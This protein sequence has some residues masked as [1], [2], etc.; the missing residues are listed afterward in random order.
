[1][2]AYDSWR[3]EVSS[4]DPDATDVWVNLTAWVRTTGP[5]VRPVTIRR[6]RGS[7][8]E[9][10]QA[11]SLT[12]FLD[13]ADHRF[14]PGNASSP[15]AAW[16]GQGRKCRLVETANGTD[17]VRFTGYLKPLDV[18]D[19]AE[20]GVDQFVTVSAVDWL[21]RLDRAPTFAGTLAEHIRTAGGQLREHFPLTDAYPHVSSLTLATL[22]REVFGFFDE[23]V[24][25][26]PEDLIQATDTDGPP[27]DDQRYA[28]W[29]PATDAEGD[30]FL[31]HA[32][33]TGAIGVPVGAAEVLA[34]S[35]WVR[36]TT[37]TV[38]APALR[39][40]SSFLTVGNTTDFGLTIRDYR[41]DSSGVQ[42]SG[43]SV[44]TPISG[45]R[46]LERDAWRLVT[47]RMNFATGSTSLWVGAD[48][49]ATGTAAPPAG[50][51]LTT[52]A[53]GSLF[54]G[55]LGHIQIRVGPDATTM[56]RADHLAQHA[57][58]YRGLGR[59][60]VAER[61]ATL[62]GYAGVP[63]ADL[64]LDVGAS[65]PMQP[66]RL[67]RQRPASAMRA[68]ADTE[69]GRLFVTGAGKI[70]LLA[71][72][73]RYRQAVTRQIPYEWLRRGLRF[74]E[75]NPINEA[76]GSQSGG[77][78]TRRFDLTSQQRY[79]VGADSVTLDTAI[80]ADPGNW[81][82]WTVQANSSPRVRCPQLV[83]DL[84]PLTAAERAQLLAIEIGDR[85][86]IIRS[87][88][89]RVTDTFNRTVASGWGTATSGQV[90]SAFGVGGTVAPSD[91]SVS[92][93]EGR[94]FVPV[95]LAYRAS[96]LPSVSLRDVQMTCTV[97]T[98]ISNVAGA[99]IEPASLMLRMQDISTY[100]M[101][102][103]E[104]DAS[105]A[106]VLALYG[107]SGQ[108]AAAPLS[109]VWTGQPL[110]VRA[111]IVGQV[112]SAK[113]WDPTTT[114]PLDWQVQA[115]DTAI[116]TPGAVGI[117][118]GVASGN[119][120]TKPVEFRY[121]DLEVVE[122][123]ATTIPAAAFHL[124]VEGFAPDEIGVETRTITLNTSP[125]LGP[126]PGMPPAGVM[127]GDLVSNTPIAY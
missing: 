41:A 71:R 2:A 52:I 105:E 45:G 78:S 12:L 58:G 94:H 31:G 116:T 115:S 68:A 4:A 65:T 97:D 101:A 37:Q 102:R 64:V 109:L 38:V 114:E 39:P 90:W 44:P 10:V 89:T 73:R 77:G 74:R 112:L 69:Q 50:T 34:L 127:V 51:T 57:H 108:L 47:V 119:T 46:E 95:D 123:P 3:F 24:P 60:T 16:W 55:S 1:M 103:L 33:L 70:T 82:A 17:F 48:L 91:T 14:T 84:L 36:P 66:A 22:T 59:Q 107:P 29:A 99:A 27:G 5:G 7:E 8:R 76:S 11:S 83:L 106:V 32:R 43:F 111:A 87:G 113:A 30:A 18:A 42:V 124:I 98:F 23:P 104:I 118:S 49:V 6:G 80:D 92:G 96:W 100:Y 88:T 122:Y 126:A 15:Y 25:A 125:L 86:E 110:R 121:D 26:E 9:D 67:A 75:D 72:Q 53:V 61:I 63:S 117:R 28:R 54:V 40:N 13:N 56:T 62:G 20:P 120:N 19:W 21:G 35:V 93:T 79:G 81:A 85:I